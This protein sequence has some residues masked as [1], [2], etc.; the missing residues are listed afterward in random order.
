MNEE[1]A[2]IPPLFTLESTV[3]REGNREFQ[4]LAVRKYGI[5]SIVIIIAFE[6]FMIMCAVGLYGGSMR[7]V[8][9]LGAAMM[10]ISQIAGAVRRTKANRAKEGI[11]GVYL[12]YEDCF[13]I[14][15]VGSS[16]NISYSLCD[17]YETMKFFIIITNSRSGYVFAKSEFGD[18]TDNFREFLRVR[19][20]RKNTL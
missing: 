19:K 14:L 7:W 9:G 15:S 1:K 2:N 20:W 8:F 10:I 17:V 12:F 3:T 13:E 6:V 11:K 18:D 5:G 16:A 4:R